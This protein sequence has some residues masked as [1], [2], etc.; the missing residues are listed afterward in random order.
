VS[1][2]TELKRRNVFRIGIA[3]LIVAW[4]LMQVAALAVPALRLP[5]WV[6]TFVVFILS[7]GLPVALL[8]AWAFEVTPA[9][10]RKTKDVPL[11]K[12][13]RNLTGQRLN[14]AVIALLVITVVVLLIERSRTGEGPDI[15][16]DVTSDIS[17]AVLPFE[18]LSDDVSQEHFVDGLT[19]ELLN[20]L[21]AIDNFRVI[22]RTSSF[23]YKG[24]D[25]PVPVIANEL[26]VSHV[27]E[28]SVRRAGERIRVTAQ[29]ID[30]RTDSHVWFEN[31][32]RALTV[33]NVLEIQEVI[34]NT[35]A[36][37]LQLK[38]RTTTD[39]V[40]RPASIAALDSY[41]DGMFHLRRFQLQNYNE[42]D[43]S[44]YEAAVTAFEASIAEDPEW[45]P[46]YAGLGQIQHFGRFMGDHTEQ[47]RKSRQNIM[48]ALE[49]D[50]TLGRAWASLG[51]INTI[52]GNY[53]A[54][55]D[56]YERARANGETN[57]WGY[58]ILWNALGRYEDS[59]REFREAR[60]RDPL[61]RAIRAQLIDA[62]YC[63]GQ[64]N[65][66]VDEALDLAR[67]EPDNNFARVFLADAYSA[68]GD[69]ENAMMFA[70]QVAAA[71]R[72]ETRIAYA[73]A[74]SGQAARARAAIEAAVT[75]GQF[76]WTRSRAAVVLGDD[77]SAI[78]ILEAAVS[79]AESGG[80]AMLWN[81]GY[82]RCSPE[83]LSLEG[84]PRYDALIEGLD[85]VK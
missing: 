81:L 63:A 20:S 24:K 29:L 71:S 52:E 61:A 74:K 60:R 85:F 44:V 65:D 36:D 58:A 2:F 57:N 82:M 47:L 19:E 22:S 41:H 1:L 64:Y 9:G 80:R 43:R 14:Y 83:L 50:D 59:V 79:E 42:D 27:L 33:D 70:E 35:V 76:W 6:T 49:L 16:G 66:V 54:A 5:E 39:R 56:A 11:E 10:I 26:D 73:L 51:Y 55:L 28:G 37:R 4:L 53:S 30:T 75:P 18:N 72:A 48:R 32:D 7:L 69:Y 34:A 67:V 15:A 78:E 3:Y 84:N 31:F 46:A 45:A 21:A 12:S 13:I 23:S 38:L 25:T 40:K 17:I 68:I 62:M 8:L 77:E